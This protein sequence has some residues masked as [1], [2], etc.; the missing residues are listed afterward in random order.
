VPSIRAAGRRLAGQSGGPL[1]AAA[2][3]LA[4]PGCGCFNHGTN[5][6]DVVLANL[7]PASLGTA[8]VVVS[9]RVRWSNHPLP[10]SP[11]TSPI[12]VEK[13][14]PLLRAEI[15][16][17]PAA[18]ETLLV[19]YRDPL[20]ANRDSIQR[21][22]SLPDSAHRLTGVALADSFRHA[23][24]P[25]YTVLS[26]DLDLKYHAATLTTYWLIPAI[27][28]RMPLSFVDSLAKNPEVLRIDPLWGE[29]PPQGPCGNNASNLDIARK[30]VESDDYLSAGHG[31]G[32]IALLDTGVDSSHPILATTGSSKI[33]NRL[34]DCITPSGDCV[35]APIQ[36]DADPQGHGTSS[37]TILSGNASLGDVNHGMTHALLDSYQVYSVPPGKKSLRVY[38]PG[39]LGAFEDALTNNHT[40]IVAEIA[41]G[42]PSDPGYAAYGDLT[43]SANWACDRGAV[44]IAANGNTAGKGI[45]YPANATRAIGVGQYCIKS[46]DHFESNSA[47]GPTADLRI[48]PD[49][50]GPSSVY[51]AAPGGATAF[52]NFSGTSGATPFAAGAALML[53]NLMTTAT[54][55]VPPGEVNALL[56]L[57]GRKGWVDAHEGAGRIQMPLGGLLWASSISLVSG[58]TATIELD[59]GD[60]P[61]SGV[62]AAVWWPEYGVANGGFPSSSERARVGLE[63]LDPT[64][65]SSEPSNVVGSVF[66][67]CSM[68]GKTPPATGKWSLQ[69][70]GAWTTAGPRDV[71][72]AAWA[73]P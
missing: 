4:L 29:G 5:K 25:R 45:P 62:E 44:V 56:V 33:L 41:D 27:L 60:L 3:L 49:I 43:G 7:S 61:V 59:P 13:V 2:L 42:Y 36:L 40:L 65:A 51:V 9:A 10:P 52:H 6:I 50:G 69:I 18:I 20:A 54:T 32:K 39:A 67:R 26:T 73:K 72:F 14:H 71:Y 16:A 1:L 24:A 70:I 17:H 30:L 64:G 23:R 66:Q 53:R 68:A 31:N 34:C 47:W 38:I 57:C 21:F 15:L 35:G 48:K 58:K 11:P 37:A 12:P 8:P 28:V 46:P 22:L 19:V 63:I 55:P